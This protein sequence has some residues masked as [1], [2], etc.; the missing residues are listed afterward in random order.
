MTDHQ[1]NEPFT[2]IVLPA[3]FGLERLKGSKG[4]SSHL[5]DVTVFSLKLGV[6]LCDIR[7]PQAEVSVL[8]VSSHDR[9]IYEAN[10]RLASSQ[11]PV[12]S[13]QVPGHIL[14]TG[15]IT[16]YLVL[17]AGE[18]GSISDIVDSGR[19]LVFPSEASREVKAVFQSF[20]SNAERFLIRGRASQAAAGS[21]NPEQPFADR[22]PLPPQQWQSMTSGLLSAPT[23]EQHQ[24]MQQ[25]S[26]S[27]PAVLCFLE[28]PAR[29]Q[30]AGAGSSHRTGRVADPNPPLPDAASLY[31]YEHFLM[32]FVRH[33]ATVMYYDSTSAL[34]ANSSQSTAATATSLA[35]RLL[36]FLLDNEM[37]VCAVLLLG[38]FPEVAEHV[39]QCGLEL[40][41]GC[42]V[43]QIVLLSIF[44]CTWHKVALF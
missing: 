4:R 25:L 7:L 27:G 28:D 2:C 19:V 26:R 30:A 10:F 39:L 17:C 16:A 35:V 22:Q 23:S 42:I 43:S 15:I 31:A 38:K 29:R 36:H 32:P 34:Q 21:R 11:R 5:H 40:P 41:G 20:V 18:N 14:E 33:W 9:V 44:A 37:W 13:F 8:L 1:A 24:A 12:L 3:G 6:R